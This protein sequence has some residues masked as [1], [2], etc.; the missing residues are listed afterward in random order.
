MNT[1]PASTNYLLAIALGPVQ[2]FISA[3]RRTRDLWFGSFLLSEISKAAART[4]RKREGQLI[5][6]NPVE[7][8]KDLKP[9]SD[10]NV[11]NII[12]A[13]LH[14]GLSPKGI[15]DDAERAARA[16]WKGH[17]AKA[18]EAADALI[19][20]KT[21]WEEQIED[22]IEFYAAWAPLEPDKKYSDARGQV[23]R[24]LA[25]A[26]PCVISNFIE[27][28]RRFPSRHSM[29]RVRVFWCTEDPARKYCSKTNASLSVCGFHGA[30]N[31]TP[32]A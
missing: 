11:V 25:A 15:A 2:D 19:G 23:M 9:A 10:F 13:E 31:W 6:P 16:C 28:G 18:K 12:L 26:R 27:V 29:V 8:D 5:F 22:V 20:D 30:R 32:S 1:D 4:V 17:A 21:L 7:P 14:G 3:A 24:L